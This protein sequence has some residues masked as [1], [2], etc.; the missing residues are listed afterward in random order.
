MKIPSG[1]RYSDMSSTS[2]HLIALYK[3]PAVPLSTLS[4]LVWAYCIEAS[5]VI[6]SLT[7]V[8]PATEMLV[9]SK[10]VVLSTPV[11][12]NCEKETRI[13]DFSDPP[14]TDKLCVPENPVC[15]IL[16]MLSYNFV[17]SGYNPPLCAW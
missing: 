2:G 8:F 7:F 10:P 1:V 13:V 17:P 9:R 16:E 5:M 12:F 11:E 15:K 3:R 6:Q 14:S 4:F